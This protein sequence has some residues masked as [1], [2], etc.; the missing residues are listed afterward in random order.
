MPS[1][2][3][4]RQWRSNDNVSLVELL[5]KL[6][7]HFASLR[8]KVDRYADSK[9]IIESFIWVFKVLLEFLFLANFFHFSIVAQQNDL[10][11]HLLSHFLEWAKNKYFRSYKTLI[12]SI[13]LCNLFFSAFRR[14]GEHF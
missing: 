3:A 5:V 13:V 1:K 8:I 11:N 2:H 9:E 6:Q 4:N 10:L 14:S 7:F 12:S